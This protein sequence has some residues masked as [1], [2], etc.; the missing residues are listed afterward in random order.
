M[1]EL[2]DVRTFLTGIIHMHLQQY[3]TSSVNHWF[4]VMRSHCFKERAGTFFS[5]AVSVKNVGI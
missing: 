5:T 1:C 2:S 3:L 4:V